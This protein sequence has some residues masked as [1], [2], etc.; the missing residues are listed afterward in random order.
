MIF[1]KSKH[2]GSAE[3]H[4]LRRCDNPLFEGYKTSLDD[5]HLV[6]AQRYDHDE[7]LAFQQA[8]KE[9]LNETLNL[10]SNVD[11]DVILALKNQLEQIYEQGCRVADEQS[12]TLQAIEKL[13]QII[14]GSIRNG[15]GNDRQAHQELDQEDAARQA[16]FALLKSNLVADLLNP[17]TV[18][19]PEHLVPTL[20]STEKD[21]LS[22]VLQ[23]FDEAQLLMILQQAEALTERLAGNGVAIQTA[24]E[25]FAFIQGYLH[26]LVQNQQAAN[27]R[28]S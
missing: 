26:Y 19:E 17:E 12:E 23:I 9:A 10:K 2:P 14:M 24:I 27:N 8:F 6:E 22:L 20:L 7:V 16:H 1:E 15:A 13:L 28:S 5:E 4:L 25:N 18:I 21:E 3:R 11:S